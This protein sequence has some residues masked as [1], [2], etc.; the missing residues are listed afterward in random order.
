MGAATVAV[1]W[2]GYAQSVLRDMGVHLPA[3]IASA[4]ARYDPKLEQWVSTGGIVNLPAMLIL[5]VLTLLNYLGIHESARATRVIVALKVAVLIVFVIAGFT[6]VKPANWSP[7]VPP[8]GDKFGEYGVGGILRASSVL[9]FAFIGA[10]SVSCAAQEA[11][12]PQR[13][14]P[15]G[16]LASLGICSVLYILVSLSPLGS[17]R[18][19]MMQLLRHLQVAAATDILYQR[20][21]ARLLFHSC[22][23]FICHRALQ[24]GLVLTGVVPYQDLNVPDPI[25]VAVDAGGPGYYWLRPCVKVGALLGLTSVI[26]VLILGQSRIWFAMADDRM[27]PPRLAAIHPKYR[28]PH[29][30]VTICGIMAA[31]MAGVVPIDI[32]GEMVSGMN[33]SPSGIII[34]TIA[35]HHDESILHHEK[36]MPHLAALYHGL[37]MQLPRS[38]SLFNACIFVVPC[39]HITNAGLYRHSACLCHHLHWRAGASQAA[40]KSGSPIQDALG[41]VHPHCRCTHQQ[42]ADGSSAL[43]DVAAAAGVDGHRFPCLLFLLAQARQAVCAAARHAASWFCPERSAWCW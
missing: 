1:G 5:A 9:F 10:D 42:P 7:F 21:F 4:P 11:V 30:A 35:K 36:R 20:F 28:T 37:P 2:S 17:V 14:V 8:A 16:T 31:A 26:L 29:V 33:A 6:Y 13:D 25:A 23:L 34:L 18:I 3:A 39:H 38:T 19:G 41:A 15:I 27:L 24:V 43:G 12:N 40:A 22:Y 32:L